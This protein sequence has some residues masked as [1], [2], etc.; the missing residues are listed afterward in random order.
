MPLRQTWCGYAGLDIRTT[1]DGSVKAAARTLVA[2]QSHPRP[3]LRAPRGLR[4][5][6]PGIQLHLTAGH[7]CTPGAWGIWSPALLG[8]WSV[9]SHRPAAARSAGAATP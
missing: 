5:R 4:R 8:T 3:S 6:P 7:G 9:S 1:T 2:E